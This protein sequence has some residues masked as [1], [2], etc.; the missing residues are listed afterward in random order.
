MQGKTLLNGNKVMT[1][2][3]KEAKATIG[4]NMYCRAD[5]ALRLWFKL[6]FF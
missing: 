2:R 6:N 4:R 3:C 5:T 1:L